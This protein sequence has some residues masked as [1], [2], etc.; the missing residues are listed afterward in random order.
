MELRER[1]HQ[2]LDPLEVV[3]VDGLLELSDRLQ[4]FDMGFELGPARKAVL[5]GNLKLRV[6]KRRRSACSEQVLG[7]VLEMPQV[8]MLGKRT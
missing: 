3:G 4:R 6:G 8:G 7:L 5:P 1:G 2:L